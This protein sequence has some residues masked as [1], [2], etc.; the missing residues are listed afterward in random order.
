MGGKLAQSSFMSSVNPTECRGLGKVA[1]MVST[2]RGDLT[3]HNL[4]LQLSLLYW[5]LYWWR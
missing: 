1:A 3:P 2:L 5:S 4:P